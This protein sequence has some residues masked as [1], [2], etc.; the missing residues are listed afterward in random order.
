MQYTI[1]TQSIASEEDIV[2]ARRC[3]RQIA[4]LIG[5]DVQNQTR[6]ATAVS[7]VVR[8]TYEQAKSGK[9]EYLVDT[10]Q[11]HLIIRVSDTSRSEG[12]L[13]DATNSSVNQ[14]PTKTGEWPQVGSPSGLIAELL[15]ARQLV[16]FFKITPAGD[17]TG[18][19]VT[20]Q[21]GKVLPPNVEITAPDIVKIATA[22]LRANPV[23][24]LQE[25]KQQNFELLIAL[26]EVRQIQTTLEQRVQ[27]RTSE[28]AKTN[29]A[30]ESEISERKR[31]ESEIQRLNT[32]LENRIE[33]RTAELLR[34][35]AE[36]EAFSYSVSHDLRAPLRTID[37]LSAILGK[38]YKVVLGEDGQEIIQSIHEDVMRMNTLID[39]LLNLSK[40]TRT[41]M[42]NEAVNFSE[43]ARQVIQQLQRL[44]PDRKITIQIADSIDVHGDASLLRII[45]DNL[46]GNAWKFTQK[47]PAP[48]IEFDMIQRD[49]HYAYFIRDNGAGFDMQYAG[50]LFSPFQ[51]LH[52]NTDFQGT[53]IGLAIVQR[54]IRRHGGHIWADSAIGKGTTFTFT[55][56]E[57]AT[58]AFLTPDETSQDRT[59]SKSDET[60]T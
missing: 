24:P 3:A 7:E 32:D 23:S 4:G 20:I 50:K 6:I 13:Y 9:A 17:A 30:L 35:N 16:D 2:V 55:L 51:R 43:L 28:L 37:G 18:K 10:D 41:I 58:A 60:N 46:L 27:S 44:E 29:Q 52:S 39:D 22:L 54:I 33:E 8:N 42:T 38:R 5:F 14:N 12:Q 53:G 59:R 26:E 40:V 49:R 25:V 57:T 36:L 19:G 48:S 31:A 47:Q 11:S 15:G 45:L 56:S 1:I 34:V 21:L